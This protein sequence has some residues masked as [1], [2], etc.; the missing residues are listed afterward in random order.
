[1]SDLRPAGIPVI[2]GGEEWKL[3][4]TL[5]AM[6]ALESECDKPIGEIID[7]LT[8]KREAAKALKKI[9]A[10]LLNDSLERE[11]KEPTVTER[12]VGWWVHGGNVL[13][14]TMAVLKAYGYSLPEPDEFDQGNAEAGQQES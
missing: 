3:L 1:M 5:N 9:L 4:F 10:A 2:L 13:E 12:D 8:D 6:D 11:G 7:Q 14:V